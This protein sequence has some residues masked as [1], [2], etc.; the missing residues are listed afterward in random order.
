MIHRH[1]Q[2]SCPDLI[3]ASTETGTAVPLSLDGRDKPGHDD[4]YRLFGSEQYVGLAREA[5][6]TGDR[7]AAENFYQHAEH[8]FRLNNASR[9][10]N[11]Q[12]MPL[13]PTTGAEVEVNASQAGPS[14]EH[15]AGRP[16]R[17][18]DDDDPISRETFVR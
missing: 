18:S 13:R 3:R 11:Q 1:P 14:V 4:V 7:V 9:E 17:P 5:E 16:R 15:P 2:P 12:G 10:A 8:Y 6:T